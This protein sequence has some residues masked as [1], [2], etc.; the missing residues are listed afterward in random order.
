MIQD[1]F[2]GASLLV[3]PIRMEPWGQRVFRIFDPDKHVVEL[4]E[5]Q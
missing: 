4:G 3:H 1:F 5:P 2:D